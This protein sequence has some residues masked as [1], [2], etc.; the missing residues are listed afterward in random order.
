MKTPGKH[1][2]LSFSAYIGAV[3]DFNYWWINFIFYRH[4]LLLP[5]RRKKFDTI[6]ILKAVKL[7]NEIFF[8]EYHGRWLMVRI[9]VNFPKSPDLSFL[10]VCLSLSIFKCRNVCFWQRFIWITMKLAIKLYA[11]SNADGTHG[12]SKWKIFACYNRT[13]WSAW[14]MSDCIRSAKLL[15]CKLRQQTNILGGFLERY[16][17]ALLLSR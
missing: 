7:W 2:N 12:N 10:F 4:V 8:I 14:D 1:L 6:S 16:H 11:D 13:L 15:S 3:S 17:V 5:A 9:I